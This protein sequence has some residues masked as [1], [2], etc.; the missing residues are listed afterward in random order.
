V[1]FWKTIAGLAWKWTVGPPLLAL[2]LVAGVVAYTTVSADYR[3]DTSLVLATPVNGGVVSKDPTKPVGVGNPLLQFND[4]LKTAASIVIQSM[5]TQDVWTQLGAPE[6]GPTKI[7]IDDGRSNPDVLDISGPYIY[8]QVASHSPQTVTTVLSNTQKRVRQELINWQKALGAP[9]STYLTVTY[10]VPPAKPEVST[11]AKW[12]AG[13]GLALLVAF[14]GLCA[15]Y[16]RD[17]RQTPTL[18]ISTPKPPQ[19]AA[20]PVVNGAPVTPHVWDT[21]DFTAAKNGRKE[22]QK[23]EPKGAGAAED[24]GTMVIVLGETAETASGDDKD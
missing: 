7:T 17:R 3:A 19:A 23:A 13:L 11:T 21:Q 24:D 20:K 1:G 9:P 8:I 5:N 18:S 22:P 2:S 14:G 4:A 6:N 15:L 16:W 12:E 10:I